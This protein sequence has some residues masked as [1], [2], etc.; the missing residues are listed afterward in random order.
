MSAGLPLKSSKYSV[1]PGAGEYTNRNSLRTVSNTIL[2]VLGAVPLVRG[3]W[4]T[5]PENTTS[6]VGWNVSVT[7]C[8][9]IAAELAICVTKWLHE[10]DHDLR[11][12]I[13]CSQPPSVGLLT[14]MRSAWM[15]TSHDF[16]AAI[17]VPPIFSMTSFPFINI[18]VSFPIAQKSG[19]GLPSAFLFREKVP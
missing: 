8:P 19:W 2:P 9:T 16:A 17:A 18:V 13:E 5:V 12:A 1:T 7:V 3:G 4:L 6:L 10:A 15:F 14:L 11:P